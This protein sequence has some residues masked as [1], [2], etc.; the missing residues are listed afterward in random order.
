MKVKNSL[1]QMKLDLKSH[2]NEF[3]QS[4]QEQKLSSSMLKTEQYQIRMQYHMWEKEIAHLKTQTTNECAEAENIHRCTMESKQM[5]LEICKVDI[6][7]LDKEKELLNL[8]LLLAEAQLTAPQLGE[9]SSHTST[10]S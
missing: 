3:S 5:D 1:E 9:G 6:E 2:L 4:A 10:V 7:M 8:K